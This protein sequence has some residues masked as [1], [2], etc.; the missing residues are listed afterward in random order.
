MTKK[1]YI[2]MDYIVHGFDGLQ[3]LL[4][5]LL[6]T[7]ISP[8]WVPP[9]VIGYMLHKVFGIKPGSLHVPDDGEGGWG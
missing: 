6:A 5:I 1:T 4:I 8:L 7:A 2:V 3:R 9:L